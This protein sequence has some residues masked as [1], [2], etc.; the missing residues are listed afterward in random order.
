MSKENDFEEYVLRM[1]EETKRIRQETADLARRM[2]EIFKTI[3][4]W[5]EKLASARTEEERIQ[6]IN[7]WAGGK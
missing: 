7:E 3:D 5:C 2:P 1:R 4:E 6:I